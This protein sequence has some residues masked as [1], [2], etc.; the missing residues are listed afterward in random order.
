MIKIISNIFIVISLVA[1][2]S[3]L[4]ENNSSDESATQSEFT[5]QKSQQESVVKRFMNADKT[6]ELRTVQQL[7]PVLDPVYSKVQS[8]FKQHNKENAQNG[9]YVLFELGIEPNGQVSSICALVDKVNDNALTADLA[10]LLK[11]TDFTSG[12]FRFQ[13]LRYPASAK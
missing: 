9:E 2:L 5:C 13:L 6:K 7:K 1:P 8:L 4:A 11:T 10:N 3:L 12:D